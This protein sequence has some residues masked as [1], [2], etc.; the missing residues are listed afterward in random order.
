MIFNFSWKLDF[1]WFLAHQWGFKVNGAQIRTPHIELPLG[2]KFSENS[3]SIGSWLTNEVSEQMELRF[4]LPASNYPLKTIFLKTRFLLVPGP[5]MG[6]P[7]KWSSD[8]K[9]PHRITFSG[10]YSRKN[11]AFF[12]WRTNA[13]FWLA[14]TSG[15]TD[16]RTNEFRY[17][18][19]HNPFFQKRELYHSRGLFDLTSLQKS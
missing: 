7:G 5:P 13:V 11:L 9:S 14:W 8:S 18:L 17:F 6:F 4:E 10:A 3:I 19:R 2:N 16:I 15:Q 1:Y 12:Y